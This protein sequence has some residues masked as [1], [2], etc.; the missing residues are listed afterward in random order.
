[1]FEP[2]CLTPL[3]WE[4]RNLGMPSYAISD[5]FFES[6]DEIM[7]ADEIERLFHQNGPIFIQARLHKA[8]LP[9]AISLQRVGFIYAESTLV[10]TTILKKNRSLEKFKENPSAFIPGLYDEQQI[11]FNK[12]ERSDETA[13][14]SIRSI[15]REAFVDDRFHLDPKCPPQMADERF[16]HWVNDLA[17]DESVIF[18]ILSLK[19][20]PLAFMTRKKE[21]LILAGFGKE[22]RLSGLGDYLWLS[23]L[24]DMLKED[25]YKVHTLFSVYNTGVMNLYTRLG[26]NFT[27]PCV[28]F[29]LWK[30]LEKGS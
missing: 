18:Y 15:A 17:A 2:S 30:K 1:M 28:T 13:L 21:N 3:P 6:F 25:L 16:V 7:L 26:F 23:V 14:Q 29:H 19:N 10:P 20:V 22:Y 8:Q 5:S 9:F 24:L 27:D 11:G 12:V 4:T